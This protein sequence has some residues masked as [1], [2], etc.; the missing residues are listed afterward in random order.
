MRYR[1]KRRLYF[2]FTFTRYCRRKGPPISKDRIVR[3][4][5]AFSCVRRRTDATS[6]NCLHVLSPSNW[7][8]IVCWSR[9]S[10]TRHSTRSLTRRFVRRLNG[11]ARASQGL[12]FICRCVCYWTDERT[13]YNLSSCTHP[14]IKVRNVE[15]NGYNWTVLIDWLI[16]WS[17]LEHVTNVHVTNWTWQWIR[18]PRKKGKNAHSKIETWTHVE[19]NTHKSKQWK[20]WLFN[21]YSHAVDYHP[22]RFF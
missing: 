22:N 19:I 3:G 13:Q 7:R 8:S 2:T 1:N 17:L 10:R 11:V 6:S 12:L 14:S 9:R 20:S 16:D 4:G 5:T 15:P 18:H 21:S